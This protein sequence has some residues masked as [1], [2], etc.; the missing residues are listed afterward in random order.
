MAPDTARRDACTS[1]LVQVAEVTKGGYVPTS[2]RTELMLQVTDTTA[3]L[4]RVQR[5]RRTLEADAACVEATEKAGKHFESA[6]AIGKS[7]PAI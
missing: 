3:R 2:L 7:E 5:Q 4:L 6:Q 1:P